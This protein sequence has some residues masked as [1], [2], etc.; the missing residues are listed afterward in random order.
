MT[1]SLDFDSIDKGTP[2]DGLS[3]PALTRVAL[4]RFAGSIDD[5]NPMHLDDKVAMAAGKS[6]VYA[7]SNLVMAYV[8]R[9]V[10]KLFRRFV[11]ATLRAAH[12]QARLAG[13]ILTCRGV[14]I[15]KR[16]E[17]GEHVIDADVWADNQRGE[18][19][20]KG[21]VLTVVPLAV[22]KPEQS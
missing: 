20:A 15:D 4:A 19:V 3:I 13:D 14:V 7:P 11:T 10:E 18:T 22:V 12:A 17:N 16:I 5:Y 1:K 8:G 9:M 21:R 2:I 6:S